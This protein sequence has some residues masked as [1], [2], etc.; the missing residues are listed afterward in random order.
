MQ[1]KS[2]D[3]DNAHNYK[4]TL[5]CLSINIYLNDQSVIIGID[6]TLDFKKLH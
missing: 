3:F 5:A 6:D 1:Y 2:S 4:R